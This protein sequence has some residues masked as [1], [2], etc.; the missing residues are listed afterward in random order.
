VTHNILQYMASYDTWHPA[1]HDTLGHMTLC[2][3]LF[4]GIVTLDS[5]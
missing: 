5:L 1:T 4:Y 2:D 3:T